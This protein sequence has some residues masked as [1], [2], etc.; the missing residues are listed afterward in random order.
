MQNYKE[1]RPWGTFEVLYADDYCKIKKITVN[2]DQQL[3]LQYHT[4]REEH[5]YVTEGTGLVTCGNANWQLATG[6][7][8]NIP[9]MVPHRISNFEKEKLV[10]IEVQ[11]GDSFDEDDIVRLDDIYNRV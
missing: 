4:K 9:R 5:W 2:P 11:T 1:E 3:S 6:M 7:G 8:T 10:F